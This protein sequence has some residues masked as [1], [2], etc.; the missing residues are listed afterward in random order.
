MKC[1]IITFMLVLLPATLLAMGRH[2]QAQEQA[3]RL[4]VLQVKPEEEQEPTNRWA[5]VIGIGEYQFPGVP[6]LQ[7]AVHDAEAMAA[8][9]E[10]HCGFPKDHIRLPTN[11]QATIQNIRH[12]LGIWLVR[13][14]KPNDI[15][16][17]YFSGHG[18]PDNDPSVAA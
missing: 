16:V 11:K 12:T 7:F 8:T 9:L 10:T 5:V 15:V 6:S 13:A 4:E 2:C 3:R 14:A 1:K 17:I 18:T